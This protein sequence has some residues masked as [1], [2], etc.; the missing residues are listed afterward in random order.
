MI[1]LDTDICIYLLNGKAPGI[2][3]Q[4]RALP[5]RSIG[6]SAIT[7]A[8]LRYGAL[9]SAHPKKN[10]ERVKIFLAP[11]QRI[12]FGDEAAEHFGRI[13]QALAKKGQLIGPMDLLIAATAL[14]VG[15]Q[16]VTNNRAEFKRVPALQVADW[17]ID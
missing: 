15:A 12:P 11:L 14:S 16:L 4:L 5:R 8:E 7:V 3:N 6:T 2:E 10:L 1:L 13:K 17:T 9:H